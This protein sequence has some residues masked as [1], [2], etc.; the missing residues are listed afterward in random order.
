MNRESDSGVMALRL[1]LRR[2]NTL[3]QL[4]DAVILSNSAINPNRWTIS[5]YIDQSLSLIEFDLF[6][7]AIVSGS[8]SHPWW[9]S[10]FP[11]LASQIDSLHH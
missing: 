2:R 1:E 3:L 10:V 8:S 9:L 6:I 4:V 11:F 5:I 7:L